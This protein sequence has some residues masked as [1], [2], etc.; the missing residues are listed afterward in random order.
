[1]TA[2]LLSLAPRHAKRIF[3]G[4]KHFEFRRTTPR[5]SLPATAYVYETQ[6]TGAVVGMFLVTASLG[7]D[8]DLPSLEEDPHE[9]E[10]VEEYLRG[11]AR[12]TALTVRLPVRFSEPI[13]LSR[14]GLHRAPQ[15]YQHVPLLGDLLP[16][17]SRSRNRRL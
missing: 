6:P 17:A 11:A 9:R 2:V 10:A 8:T 12:P 5:L 16:G 1:M 7:G 4:D 14:W 13:P 15:S 3:D